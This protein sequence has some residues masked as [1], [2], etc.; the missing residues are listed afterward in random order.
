MPAHYPLL[1]ISFCCGY[2]VE[3]KRR[4]S[5]SN[6][7]QQVRVCLDGMTP[8]KRIA[9]SAQACALLEKQTVWR[10][11]QSIF[12]YAPL[13]EELDILAVLKDSLA[14]GKTVAL[15]RFD[16]ASNRYVA[17]RVRDLDGD[18]L[19]GRFGIREPAERCPSLELTRLDLTLVPGLAFD[20]QGRRLGRGKGFYDE[21][22]ASIGGITCGVAFDEQILDEIP[23]EPHD[24]RVHCILTPTR[25]M[26]SSPQ[27]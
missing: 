16:P 25:W 13:P 23:I 9:A 15:P 4:D 1:Q 6:L 2:F 10:E 24:V 5:K 17:C 21:L 7:R 18:V 3:L 12:F 22:L 11:A 20:A 27:S 8:S 14:A 26:E 19:N